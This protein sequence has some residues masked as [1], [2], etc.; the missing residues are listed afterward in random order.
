MTA[1]AALVRDRALP[2]SY[3]VLGG[4]TQTCSVAALALTAL[5][6]GIAA[7]VLLMAGA[8]VSVGNHLRW[9]RRVDGRPLGSSLG[10]LGLLAAV[11]A[12]LVVAALAARAVVADLPWLAALVALAAGAATATLLRWW[13][14]RP[15]LS[16]V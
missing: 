3:A 9:R 1:P 14:L 2:L 11:V 8:L 10:T 5:G 12:V 15:V 13:Q 16:P 7:W 6:H 4:V